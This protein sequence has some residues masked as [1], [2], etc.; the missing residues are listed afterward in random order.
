MEQEQDHGLRCDR[1]RQSTGEIQADT[2]ALV[3][4][5]LC[6]MCRDGGVTIK[7]AREGDMEKSQMCAG[8]GALTRER[9]RQKC[10]CGAYV[11]GKGMKARR[12]RILCDFPELAD[13][14]GGAGEPDCL[15]AHYRN[16]H[17][18]DDRRFFSVPPEGP[19]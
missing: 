6:R 17:F 9:L 7:N 12:E 1:C 13:A 8:C 10:S 15:T 16:D 11:C 14:I 4:L 5:W 2:S 3:V 19:I 18:D